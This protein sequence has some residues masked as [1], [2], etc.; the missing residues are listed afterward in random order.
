M[1]QSGSNSQ[2]CFVGENSLALLEDEWT[3]LKVAK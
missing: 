3:T 2:V 1:Q